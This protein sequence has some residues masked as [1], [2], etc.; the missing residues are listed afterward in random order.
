MSTRE[1]GSFAVPKIGELDSRA[2][3]FGMLSRCKYGPQQNLS[4]QWLSQV[5]GARVLSLDDDHRS[6]NSELPK[7]D[8]S[9]TSKIAK[10]C[11]VITADCLPVL[12]CNAQGTEVAAVHAGWRGLVGGILTNA[13]GQFHARA[14]QLQVYLGP[15]ISSACFEV[16]VEVQ[17]AFVAHLGVDAKKAFVPSGERSDKLYANLYLLATIELQALGLRS[18]V[19]GE[20]CTYSQAELFYSHRRSCD[21]GRMVSAIWL[22]DA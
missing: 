21:S 20:Y 11:A 19:G 10:V 18:I 12:I 7:A 9:Y 5:H 4:C 13:I 2:D 1:A 16:G 17:E 15:A 3:R 8:A 6:P 22:C 14:D